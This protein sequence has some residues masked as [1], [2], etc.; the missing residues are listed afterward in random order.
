MRLLLVNDLA[1]C[2]GGAEVH[3][4]DLIPGL[5]ERGHEVA[6]LHTAVPDPARD[7]IAPSDIP[8]WHFDGSNRGVLDQARL[9]RP[10]VVYAHRI[11]AVEAAPSLLDLAPSA[12]FLHGY[13][14]VC[15][16]GS[17]CMKAPTPTPCGREF[18]WQCLAFYYPRRCGGLN[19]RTMWREFQLQRASRAFLHRFDLRLTHSKHVR[20][21]YVRH[22][23]D[24]QWTRTIPFFVTK[25]AGTTE[26]STGGSPRRVNDDLV[27]LLFMGRF[28]VLKGGQVLLRALP[29]IQRR[30][31]RPVELTMAGDGPIRAD[32]EAL[33]RRVTEGHGQSLQ[34]RFPGWL[35]GEI[36]R[37]V[38]SQADLLVVPSLWPEPFGMSGLEAGAMGIPAVAFDVGGVRAWLRPGINGNLASGCPP[39]ANG[40]AEAVATTVSNPVDYGLLSA[41]AQEVFRE[42]TIQRHLDALESQ[43]EELLS[44]RNR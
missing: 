6:F 21:E 20:D 18:G 11:T 29:E 5:R 31:S 34:V 35:T 13:F 4:R 10:T 38:L 9:W 14:G 33:A 19:P 24:P 32:W 15:I 1:S 25:G 16:T 30:L 8:C 2:I 36:R 42:F 17:R 37:R 28:D 27:R 12:L 43:F 23:C 26:A 3:Q 40:L 41:G 7:P 39:T 22:G 44:R